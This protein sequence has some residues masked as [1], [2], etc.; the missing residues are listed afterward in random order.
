MGCSGGAT[1]VNE[2]FVALQ[3]PISGFESPSEARRSKANNL[4]EERDLFFL[5]IAMEK[6]DIFCFSDTRTSTLLIYSS[7]AL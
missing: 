7:F 3:K 4:E 6:H 2:E 1:P 5:R